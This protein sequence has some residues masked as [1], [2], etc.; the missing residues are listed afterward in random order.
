MKRCMPTAIQP[1]LWRWAGRKVFGYAG[2]YQC[3]QCSVTLPALINLPF[4]H[5]HLIKNNYLYSQ[6]P[7]PSF[8][9]ISHYSLLSHVDWH[10]GFMSFIALLTCSPIWFISQSLHTLVIPAFVI[11]P[12]GRSEDTAG[13][14]TVAAVQRLRCQGSH[15]GAFS[16][17]ASPALKA[18]ACP[19]NSM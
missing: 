2:E 16:G 11:E 14:F 7:S 15:C 1:F 12:P 9:F 18:T 19:F 3:Q 13:H 8:F 5:F 10:A 6:G 4:S 17:P